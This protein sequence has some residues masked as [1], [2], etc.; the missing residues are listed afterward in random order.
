MSDYQG[1]RFRSSQ[2]PDPSKPADGRVP[3]QGRASSPQHAR[4][5]RPVVPAGQRRQRQ[6]TPAAYRPSAYSTAKSPQRT[7]PPAHKDMS[8][9]RAKNVGRFSLSCSSLSESD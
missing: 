8:N 4:A 7:T 9:S 6:N 1:K 3:Q 5:P 2:I